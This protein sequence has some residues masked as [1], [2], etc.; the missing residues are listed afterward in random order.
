MAKQDDPPRADGVQVTMAIVVIQPRALAMVHGH[1]G[2]GFVVLHL[3]ARMPNALQT[4]LHQL[5]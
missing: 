5:R 4:A 1:Q 2:H 3:G